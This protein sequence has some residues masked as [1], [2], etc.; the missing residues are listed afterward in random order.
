MY[1]YITVT[2]FGVA[3]PTVTCTVT[4]TVRLPLPPSEWRGLPLHY[5]YMYRYTYR[6]ITVT[7]FGVAR[8]TVTL[9]LHYRY[10]YRYITVTSFGVARHGKTA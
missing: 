6:Y 10:M 7:S 5:R 9:P 4:F 8:P 2:S 1:R 3:R